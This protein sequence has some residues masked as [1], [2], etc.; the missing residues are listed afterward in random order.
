MKKRV[1]YLKIDEKQFGDEDHSLEIQFSV[2]YKGN[3]LIPLDSVFVVDN[4]NKDDIYKITS[5]T[6]LFKDPERKIEFWCGYKGNVRK[7]FDGRI[8]KANPT[9]QPD[10]SL[11]IYAWSTLETTGDIAEIKENNIKYVDLLERVVK[12][13]N[14]GLVISPEV[15]NSPQLQKVASQYALNGTYGEHYNRVVSDIT[16]YNVVKDQ[17]VFTIYNNTVYVSKQDVV[18]KTLPVIIA[19]SQSGMVGIP[20]PTAT[21]VDIRMLLDVSI[22]SGQTLELRSELLP[23][24]NGLYNVYNVTHRG[25]VRDNDFYTDLQCIR[26]SG[27]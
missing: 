17:I 15:R 14:M 6:A 23:R 12:G 16:G 1:A 22:V 20:E 3:T 27:V 10:T 9:G 8:L 2:T 19:S 7:I 21:G 13:M 25:S 11:Y 18:N 24:Y 5:N 4:L 26:V